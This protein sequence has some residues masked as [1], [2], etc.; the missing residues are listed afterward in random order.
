MLLNT[1]ILEIYIQLFANYMQREKNIF[2][3]E[4]SHIALH[5]WE[6]DKYHYDHFREVKTY[7][8]APCW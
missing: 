6:H 3:S 1:L 7:D 2:E 4:S 5:S 8:T